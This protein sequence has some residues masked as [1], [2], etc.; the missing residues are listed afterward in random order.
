MVQDLAF[1]RLHVAPCGCCQVMHCVAEGRVCA[2][3]YHADG[4]WFVYL[5]GDEQP[6]PGITIPP[7]VFDSVVAAQGFIMKSLAGGIEVMLQQNAP[8]SMATH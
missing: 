1:G 3:I 8:T 5:E 2:E 4:C 6:E 7:P